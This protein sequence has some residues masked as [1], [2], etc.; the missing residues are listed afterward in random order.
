MEMKKFFGRGMAVLAVILAGSLLAGCNTGNTETGNGGYGDHTGVA[1]TGGTNSPADAAPTTTLL[2]KGEEVTVMFSDVVSTI[3]SI[4]DS[5]KEDGTITLIYNQKFDADGKTIGQMQEAI[6]QRYVPQYF[7]FLTVTVQPQSRFYFV[8]GEVRGP[9][10]Q[11]Y[12]GKMTVLGAIDTAGG[13]T[14]FAR[15][16]KIDIVRASGKQIRVDGIE[17]LS[18]PEKNIEI[19]PGDRVY[20]N[21]RM[22]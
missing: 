22:W 7:K 6:R 8:G 3:P 13:Y 2:H 18:H 14:D 12:V 9:G 19:F 10:R 21:K 5:I 20:V 17:A 11:A 4:T 1:H 15:R 16:T